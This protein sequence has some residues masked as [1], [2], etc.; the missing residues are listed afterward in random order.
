M[1]IELFAFLEPAVIDRLG[2]NP[3]G[4]CALEPGGVGTV[5]DHQGDFGARVGAPAGL[6]QRGQIGAA[7]GD[8]D[9]GAH[10]RAA[11]VLLS[12]RRL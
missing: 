12:H 8:Q 11:Q 6:R 4:A 1:P 3:G 7:P 2:R 5:G 10:A 9:R